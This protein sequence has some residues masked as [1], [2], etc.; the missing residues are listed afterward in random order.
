MEITEFCFITYTFYCSVKRDYGV[1]HAC[2]T[3]L[4]SPLV[5]SVFEPIDL[6]QTDQTK[7]ARTKT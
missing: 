1:L 7:L 3:E 6:L 2:A 5:I 4:F